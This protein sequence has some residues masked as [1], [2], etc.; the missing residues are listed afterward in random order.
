MAAGDFDSQS[1]SLFAAMVTV[2]RASMATSGQATSCGRPM[3]PAPRLTG[4]ALIDPMASGGHAETDLAMLQLFG[5][6]YLD[7][8]L[9]SYDEV[10]PLADGWRERVGIHQLVPVLLHCVL[11]GELRRACAL[12]C[13]ALCVGLRA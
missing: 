11:F 1:R 13:P 7:D 10:S 5:C 3:A 4:A 9:A 8:L 2:A 12:Y 6:A